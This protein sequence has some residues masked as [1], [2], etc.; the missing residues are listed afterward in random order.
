MLNECVFVGRVLDDPRFFDGTIERCQFALAVDRDYIGKDE[1]KSD[2]FRFVAW[3]STAVYV[4]DRFRKGDLVSVKSS[5]HE[6]K[7]EDSNGI[8]RQDYEFE[9]DRAY[10]LSKSLKHKRMPDGVSGLT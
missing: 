7:Y 2:V 8:K 4:R 6:H 9:V 1:V 10:L 3:S 5:A